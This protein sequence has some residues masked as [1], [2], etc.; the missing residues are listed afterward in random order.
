[1]S[2]ASSMAIGLCTYNR[3]PKI[4][5]TL[6]A[7]AG[8]DRAEGRV[9][10]V[11][12]IDNNCTD[13][14]PRIV[15]EFI[16]ANPSLPMVLV[17]ETTQGLAAARKRV[18]AETDEPFVAFLDD[19]C[20]PDPR[21]AAAMLARMEADGRIGAA[22]GRVDLVWEAPP[23]ALALR[24]SRSLAGQDWG[25][26]A[27]RIGADEYLVGAAM[28]LRRSAVMASGLLD[29]G[30]L[31]G[32]TGSGLTSGEDTE[33]GIRLRH[34]GYELWYEPEAVCGH[35]IPPERMTRGYLL[36]LVHA[37]SESEAWLHWLG[38][39]KPGVA[40]VEGRAARARRRL[41]RTRLLEW[42]PMRRVVRMAERR[43]R[44]AGWEQVMER[45]R[46][47]GSG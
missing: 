32:R 47:G 27:R 19:D 31:M 14:T 21:W 3:G 23:T 8:L 10:R 5:R 4:V 42:R 26:R 9:T 24:L 30:E 20:L 2:G 1:M 38:A 28:V 44:L 29:R 13:E 16:A 17:R 6:E 25:P 45:V 34:A 37:L 12:V 43:G 46:E 11:V 40:W 22:G 7:I 15:G 18:F 39:G 41:M 33:I 35:L 36:R